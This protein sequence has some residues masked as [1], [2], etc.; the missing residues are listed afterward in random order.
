MDNNKISFI[1]RI[2]LPAALFM[3]AA[4]CQDKD[5]KGYD[6]AE[7]PRYVDGV[8]VSMAPATR[9]GDD[10]D[11]EPDVTDP[12]GEFQPG[13]D[14]DNYL[15]TE[16]LADQFI[17]PTDGNP[18][19]DNRSVLYFTQF[20][21]G[22]LVPF[23]ALEKSDLTQE[24]WDRMTEKM[25]EKYPDKYPNL[26]NYSYHLKYP[27][28]YDDN[29]ATYNFFPNS[30]EEM[31]DW[32]DVKFWGR[33][34]SLYSIFAMFYPYNNVFPYDADGTPAFRV[35]TDQTTLDNLR[36]SNFLGAYFGNSSANQPLKF[37]LYHLMAYLKVTLYIPVFNPDDEIIEN[38]KKVKV[39][40]G[41]PAD[42]LQ[43]A[44]IKDVMP[45][46]AITWNANKSSGTAPST[47]AVP[48]S[49]RTN[50]SMYIPGPET[51]KDNPDKLPP[52]VK[53]PTKYFYNE[54]DKKYNEDE[55]DDCWEITLSALI[56]AGQDYQKGE[57]NVPN[58]TWTNTNFLQFDLRQN[59]GSLKRYIFNGN[60]D[61][62]EGGMISSGE[63]NIGQGVL[64]HISLYL[65]RHGEA[66]VLLNAKV[67]KWQEA[68]NDNM[69]LRQEEKDKRPEPE[70]EPE[71][72]P[73]TND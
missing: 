67:I 7:G 8:E 36:K 30:P 25:Q 56:P 38:G 66:A 58:G 69:G 62:I 60:P 49:E 43:K 16:L 47:A 19:P 72:D 64:Q 57:N 14:D 27:A 51:Y 48:S 21:P 9:A 31:M 70:P 12:E 2:F 1:Y 33:N 26:Y 10:G 11:D 13:L 50:I 45:N 54:N 5:L 23:V 4:G 32:D 52:V 6:E 17:G 73:D 3:S 20:V 35:Q 22:K 53:V 63:L 44:L 42:A 46:F 34:G 15:A 40:T 29:P 18:D 41:Y 55:T 68:Y 71:P 61:Q 24:Y 39:R 28:N 59:F 65:P 37:H